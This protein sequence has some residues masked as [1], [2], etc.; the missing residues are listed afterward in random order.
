MGQSKTD[1]PLGPEI[2]CLEVDESERR[3]STRLLQGITSGGHYAD[4]ACKCVMKSKAN[5]VLL[6]AL[7]LTSCSSSSK[8]A[9]QPPVRK[10]D[11]PFAAAGNIE[12]Q[13]DSGNYTIRAASDDHIRVSFAGNIGNATCGVGDQQQARQS[14][15]QRYAAQQFSSHNR[16]S[17]DYG[18]HGPS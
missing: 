13:L 11:K 14:G 9:E 7:V 4:L 6:A 17:H 3:R 5:L 8:P 18:S 10:A 2:A 15:D 12:M 1:S 16:S